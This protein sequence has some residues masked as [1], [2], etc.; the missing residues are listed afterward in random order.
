MYSNAT[1]GDLWESIG[2][3]AKKPVS[4]M[5]NTW[6]M[7]VGFPLVLVS[8]Q[9]SHLNLEQNRFLMELGTKKPKGLWSIP[10]SV[11]VGKKISSNLLTTKTSKIKLNQQKIIPIVNSSRKGFFRVKYDKELLSRIKFLVENKKLDY[12]DRWSI[13]N[14]LFALCVAGRERIRSYLDFSDAY[15]GDDSYLSTANVA[16]NLY[17]LYFLCFH[18]NF[19]PKIKK[20]TLEYYTELF[21]KLGWDPKKDEKHTDT[22]QRSKV[23]VILGKLGDQKII[24]EAKRRFSVFLKKHETLRPDLREAVFSLMA[25]TGDE[26]IHNQLVQ[27][28]KKAGSQ[29]AKLRVLGGLCNFR[30]EKLLLKTLN[31]SLTKDVRSQNIALPIVKIA[32]NPFGKKILWPW[33]K[34]NWKPLSEKFGFGNPLANRIVASISLVADSSMEKEI[35]QFFKKNHAPG[36]E[37]T[38]EQTLERIRIHSRFLKQI[39]TE[40]KN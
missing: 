10:I 4:S 2:H 33:L 15:H 40:F 19:E 9:N 24:H 13:Q 7:Q 25:W 39:R 29:E 14:D 18:E 1:G 16:N 37:M 34:K 5:M 23:L 11:G 27:I 6:I 30:N 32:G 31:F 35:R 38:L 28:Y 17:F 3:V 8:K 36:T 22:L 12:V 21:E 20:Y 26:K